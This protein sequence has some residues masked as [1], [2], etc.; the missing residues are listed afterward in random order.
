MVATLREGAD[1]WAAS[2]TRKRLQIIISE[3]PEVV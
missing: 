3:V 2:G 1:D